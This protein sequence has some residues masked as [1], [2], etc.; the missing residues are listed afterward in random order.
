MKQKLAILTVAAVVFAVLFV[1]CGPPQA[2]FARLDIRNNSDQPITLIT[3]D[4]VTIYNSS[5]GIGAGASYEKV[6]ELVIAG[7]YS[8]EATFTNGD[9]GTD[10]ATINSINSTSATTVSFGSGGTTDDAEYAEVTVTNNTSLTLIR[11]AFWDSSQD[12]SYETPMYSRTVADSEFPIL[13]LEPGESTTFDLRNASGTYTVGVD[14]DNDD[15]YIIQSSTV[16]LSPDT[17][18][19]YSIDDES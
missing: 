8:F 14:D 5:T 4:D 16:D 7:Q 15:P 12:P 1:S 18:A 2:G 19:T 10:S 11:I 9:T 17:P 13:G 6:V 3:M